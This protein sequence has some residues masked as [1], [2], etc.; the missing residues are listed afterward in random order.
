M[1]GL[2]STARRSRFRLA[3]AAALFSC[4]LLISPARS[5]AQPGA[6]LPAA[7]ATPAAPSLPAA[8][9][10]PA[11]IS[12]EDAWANVAEYRTTISVFERQ[13][14]E[15]QNS[16]FDYTFRKPATATVHYNDGAN[17]GVTLV[18]NGGETVAAHR[19]SG[20]MAMFT[21]TFP[22]HDPQLT[23][24][25]GSSVEQ[26]S[27]AAILAHSQ[28]TAGAISQGPGP[29]ISG[30]PTDA[31]TLVPASAAADAGLTH[32]VVDISTTLHLPVRVLGYE[33]D[34]LVRRVDFS[35]ITLGR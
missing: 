20:L 34:T 8:A 9:L 32:E 29:T 30:V 35:D 15:V 21:K 16:V 17:A 4:A 3:A 13:G 7:P 12:F 26:L 25:R 19:G 2:G 10:P 27:F 22:L 5:Q 28:G 24:I 18:W 14:A 33:G 1:N 23:T 6:A 31:V 11:W